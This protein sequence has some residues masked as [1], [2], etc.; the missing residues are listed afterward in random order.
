M[1]SNSSEGVKPPLNRKSRRRLARD[2][3]AV[4]HLVRSDNPP[5]PS[6]KPLV[7]L[8][9]FMARPPG[10]SF[11]GSRA[12]KTEAFLGGS[13]TN[14]VEVIIDSGSDITLISERALAGLSKTL[15]VK[16][17]QKINLIQVTG[18]T[19]IDGYVTLDLFFD[20]PDGPVK[21]Y[22]E[23][24]V[25]KGMTTPFI[26]GNNFTTRNPFQPS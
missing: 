9:K 16:S 24:Y 14:S 4:S 2:I 20:T 5:F 15:K 23:A 26:L 21:L 7:E 1:H 13:P 25:V 18:T 8:K 11:L 17:G 10:C 12:T 22:V 3:S 19:S 6:S